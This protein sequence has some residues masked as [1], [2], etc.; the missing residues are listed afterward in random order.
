MNAMRLRRSLP[1]AALILTMFAAPSHLLATQYPA[2]SGVLNVK[3]YGA[4]GDG[5]TDDTA[6]INYAIAASTPPGNTGIYWGQAKIVYF[7]AGTYLISGP[8]I[9]N[10]V[11]TGHA[12]YGM[13]LIGQ[14]QG[15]TTIRLAQGAPGF[16]DAAN[17]QGMIYPTSDAVDNGWSPD[18]DGNTAYQNS[19]QDLTI[20]IGTGN[21]GAIGIDY[22]A[23]NLG[24][25][26]NVTVTSDSGTDGV[27][28]IR[29]TRPII[30]PA[31]LENVTVNG[32]P[33]GLDVANL[34]YS[35][36]LD[37]VT[38]KNQ[39]VAG[40]RNSQNQITA[41]ALTAKTAGP[42]IV[43]NSADGEIVLSG[44]A[45]HRASG[46]TGNLVTNQGTIVFRN[47]N[48]VEGYQ[49]FTGSNLPNNVVNGML[50][51]SG[52]LNGA[53][54]SFN[55]STAIVSPP[56]AIST[57][58][59]NW[60]SVADFGA[61]PSADFTDPN[62]NVSTP[63]DAASGIQAAM[64]SGA[65]TIFF[66]HGVYYISTP[67]TI[68]ATVQHIVGLDSSLHPTIYEN[69]RSE[70]M[71]RV[72]ANTTTPLVIEQLR[73]DNSNDGNQLAVEHTSNRTLV[74][75]DTMFPGTLA[76]NRASG[77]G[78]LF[79]EDVSAAGS[80]VTLAG[81]SNF[82]A[83]Q[84]DFENCGT[85]MYLS[86]VPAVIVG[87]KEEGDTTEIAATNGTKV[88]VLGGLG[89]MVEN[90]TD[91]AIPLFSADQTSSLTAAF[92]EA[93]LEPCCT[94][95]N[96]LEQ[97]VNDQDYETPS[98]AFLSRSDGGHVVGMLR[99]G[100]SI[101]TPSS[102]LVA[103]TATVPINATVTDFFAANNPGPMALNLN[104]TS[105]TLAMKDQNGNPVAGSGTNTLQFNG[106]LTQV[107]AALATL[108]YTA[109]SSTGTDSVAI[110]VWNQI[111]ENITQDTFVTIAK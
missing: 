102:V 72:L 38:L 109:G 18:G 37:N 68:P 7:P 6:A 84:F 98:S 21:P 103:K 50:S 4:K 16:G 94:I 23:S 64:N 51:P 14:A 57:P 11:S 9:K 107:N 5:V 106:T 13:V 26:R 1:L 22:L 36:V 86:G 69:W 10:D 20:D 111:A 79:M 29:M 40:L 92:D 66:P 33:V 58:I 90:P 55:T 76:V 95:A 97:I 110:N 41:N 91:P 77:G 53:S 61:Q 81:S 56:A 85:C 108:T 52:F 45:L 87:F 73:F 44:G 70:G 42:A 27:A 8:L 39:T 32:F 12:T 47:S 35:L 43:N 82:Q 75:R 46:Y 89:Y 24:A 30:G 34:Q 28:G 3:T 62:D 60:V 74:L 96:Y 2:N 67:I 101:S 99:T 78:P 25:I 80:N 31:L 63:A 83:T 15:S 48:T 59:A 104:C 54:G 65:S 105:G 71:F 19:I 100:P 49:S 88:D 93:V 17:P